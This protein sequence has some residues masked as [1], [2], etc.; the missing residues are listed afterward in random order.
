MYKPIPGYNDLYHISNDGEIVAIGPGLSNPV[1][2]NGTV[3]LWKNGLP[4]MFSVEVLRR[5]VFG[6]DDGL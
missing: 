5:V 3:L 6:D 4:K 2:K 1:S